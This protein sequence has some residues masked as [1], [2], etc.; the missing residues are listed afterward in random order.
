MFDIKMLIE[1]AKEGREKA[2]MV[3]WQIDVE[4]CDDLSSRREKSGIP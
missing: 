4:L 1:K 2:Y 3:S